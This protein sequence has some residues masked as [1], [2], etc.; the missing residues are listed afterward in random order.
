MRLIDAD[1]RIELIQKTHCTGCNNYN[2]VKCRAC[3]IGDMLDYLDDAPTVDQWHYPSKGEYPPLTNHKSWSDDV[4][5]ECTDGKYRVGHYINTMG[6]KSG[7]QWD[8]W[9]FEFGMERKGIVLRW[10]YIDP[11]KEEA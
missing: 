6:H 3:D 9:W 1:E 2:K 11:P 8:N 10:Q 4:L 7:T 5:C